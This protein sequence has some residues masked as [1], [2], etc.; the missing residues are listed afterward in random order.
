MNLNFYM[1]NNQYVRINHSDLIKKN[2]SKINHNIDVLQN[3]NLTFNADLSKK[4]ELFGIS[5]RITTDILK[6]I[7][8][9]RIFLEY[10]NDEKPKPKPKAKPKPKPK[11]KPK[12]KPKPKLKAKAKPKPKP[13][14]KPKASVS[15][16]ISNI[17]NLRAQIDNFYRN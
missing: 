6:D 2:L 4:N 15:K 13:K 9:L 1:N 7:D 14:P 8:N 10:K 17:H 11:A 12:P 16:N 5:S 3:N